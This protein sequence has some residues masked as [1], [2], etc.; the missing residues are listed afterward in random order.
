[1]GPILVNASVFL[2]SMLCAANPGNA[3]DLP[4]WRAS[5]IWQERGQYD[6]YNDT[7]EARKQ[8][9][10]PEARSAVLRITADTYYRVYVNGEWVNDGPSRSWPEHYQYDVLDVAPYLKTGG[11]EIRVIAKF[12]GI[13][14]FHQLPQE[15]G[16]LAQLDV[17]PKKGDP[18]QIVTDGAWEV[19][20]APAWAKWAPKQS[21]Q[22]GP[23]EIYDARNADTG[24]F[25]PAV[26]RYPAGEG[27]WKNLEPRDCPPLTRKPFALKQFTGAQVVK[28]NEWQT[29]IFPTSCWAVTGVMKANNKCAVTGAY[30]T[31]ADL[32]QGGVLTVEADGN[33]VR[34]DGQSARD[35]VF[36]LEPGQ[37]FIFCALTEYFGH[38][39]S[40]TEIHVKADRPM[41]LK[42]PKDAN[43]STPWCYAPFDLKPVL[44]SDL[45][46]SLLT[47]EQQREI[48]R[49]IEDALK[50]HLKN[51]ATREGFQKRLAAKSRSIQPG[52]WTEAA[53]YQFKSR[54]VVKDAAA[55]VETP[56]A[57]LKEGGACTVRPS[58]KGDVELVYDLGEQN[59]GFYQFE[60]DAEAGLTVDI[61][62][63]EYIAPDGRVQDTERYRN[64]MRY[65]CSEGTN[66]FTSLV[67][68]SQ[69]YLF[70]TLRHQ[71]RPATL[72]GFRLIESTYPV[73]PVGRFE[74]SDPKLTK[75]WEIAARTLK[76]CMEDTY[77]DCP[78][79]EQT[80]WVGDSR[81][82]ALFSYTAFGSGD[83]AKR[84]LK[85]TARSLDRYPLIQSQVPST[86]EVIIPSFG[87]LWGIMAWDYYAW[88]GDKD[89]VEWIYPY[90]MKSL[91]SAATYSDKQGLFSVPFWNFFD[92]TNID[93]SHNTVLY[94]SILAAGA[95]DAALR[96]ADAIGETKDKEWLEQYRDSLKEAVNAVWNPEAGAYP[97]SVHEDGKV[98]TNFSIHNCFLS[99]LYDVVPEDRKAIVVDKLLNP[100]KDMTQ[101][102]SPFVAMYLFDALEK[103]GHADKVIEAIHR[104]YDPMLE[105]GATTVWESFPS[106]TTGHGGFP[107]R[108][109]THAWSSAPIHFLNRIVLG[110]VPET[111]GSTSFRISPRLNGLTWARGAT[112]TP[113]GPVDVSWKV[114]GKTLHIDA[115]A[116]QGV[117]LH[118]A[119]NETIAG[120]DVVFNGIK[121]N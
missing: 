42:N 38:W 48:A 23:F 97:D 66:R 13:G 93:S 60:I 81:N 1:M 50:D 27:P 94:N 56:E 6:G 105:A 33:A 45:E 37:H 28:R 74:C 16:L 91:R 109:H 87:F 25:T 95:A 67:R 103:T 26:V 79:Y 121:Q 10:L 7:I 65:V 30:A 64:G 11:N 120:L 29:F 84:C 80:L 34:V 86:W 82:E 41:V 32:P 63:V 72:N 21:V 9:D 15:A 69:R 114:D 92:W 71:T 88:S 98:S 118:Y 20:A 59:I 19:R 2:S 90:L 22:L 89:F 117:S 53:Y 102:G 99:L 100:P 18:V 68:R 5:W 113:R 49:P 24:A 77:T 40:D 39:R 12:F 46:W 43:E 106:G 119:P 116:P 73:Q 75:T 107:T 8:F 44:Y 101:A 54:E 17:Q 36:A 3:V 57:L 58:D 85:L 61:F 78:L 115:K 4:A 96:C 112:A 108:S 83:I 51:S 110:I 76:L 104:Y 31:V 35:N 111:P 47:K 14:T 55:G 52:E 62:G 70:I